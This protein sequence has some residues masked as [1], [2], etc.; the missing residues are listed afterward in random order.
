MSEARGIP[1]TIPEKIAAN[2][3]MIKGSIL[4]FKVPKTINKIDK[5]TMLKVHMD[6][7]LKKLKIL[8]S[9]KADE[10]DIQ[11]SN[12]VFS[13]KRLKHIAELATKDIV[14]LSH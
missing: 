10:L 4:Y 9:I 1:K 6:Y 14:S 12:V 3:S 7:L 11:D 2:K 8:Y 13:S 5:I